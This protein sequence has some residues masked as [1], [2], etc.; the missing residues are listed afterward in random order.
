M[1]NI[2]ILLKIL[3]NKK[4]EIYVKS[5]WLMHN[6]LEVYAFYLGIGKLITSITIK[7]YVLLYYIYR[8]RNGIT[9]EL[10]SK[11]SVNVISFLRIIICLCPK[12]IGQQINHN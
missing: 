2:L 10:W 9:K 8:I 7:F 1:T 6:S 4:K 11:T 12:K 5:N 3:F